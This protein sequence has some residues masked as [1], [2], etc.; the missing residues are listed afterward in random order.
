MAIGL[1]Y[2]KVD[3]RGHFEDACYVVEQD[4]PTNTMRANQTASWHTLHTS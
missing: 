3:K 2:A 1:A 4:L